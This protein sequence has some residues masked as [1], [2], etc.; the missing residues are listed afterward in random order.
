[1]VKW[2]LCV[3]PGNNSEN[4]ISSG[5][6]FEGNGYNFVLAATQKSDNLPFALIESDAGWLPSLGPQW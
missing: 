4:W 2:E 1:M 6:G 3:V 5:G